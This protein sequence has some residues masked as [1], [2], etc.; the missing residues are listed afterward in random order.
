MSISP[1]NYSSDKDANFGFIEKIFVW[2][3][4]FEPMIFFVVLSNSSIG[5]SGNISRLLQI[6]V[7]LMLLLRA[8]SIG[9]YNIKIPNLFYSA[10][11]WYFLYIIFAVISLIFGALTGAYD[12]NLTSKT[13]A[14][15]YS[16][17][18]ILLSG[19]LLRP[20]IEL[21]ILIYNFIYLVILPQYLLRSKKG[22]NYFFN[23]FFFVFFSS[24]FIGIIDLL[25]LYVFDYE[26]I[27]RTIAD[28]SHVGDRYHGLAGEPRDAFVYTILGMTL[29]F[30]RDYWQETKINKIWY[31]I[32]FL[33]L[34]L[35]KSFSGYVSFAIILVLLF[36]YL[37]PATKIKYS[38]PIFITCLITFPIVIYAILNTPRTLRYIESAPELLDI[39]INNRN[40]SEY[41]LTQIVNLYPIWIRF[42]NLIELNF[43]PILIGTGL[44]S[45]SVLNSIFFESKGGNF[46]PHAWIIRLIF[47]GGLIGILIFIQ[48]FLGPIKK[49]I[50]SEK[51]KMILI[52]SILS[53]LGASMGHRS[54]SIYI[55]FGITYLVFNYKKQ[56]IDTF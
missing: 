26:W 11:K 35:T 54:S 47:E 31:L 37:L 52:I 30:V 14:D 41:W 33:C 21:I 2:S 40:I 45:S 13:L 4:V 25:L 20:F 8:L 36:V 38:L 28:W 46:N 9:Y 34:L 7:L 27:P 42:T 53:V 24:F 3:L 39:F 18:T 10:Y 49:L 5:I 44:G 43:L 19:S 48:S 16:G 12:P 15:T 17:F 55:F 51:V 22:I 6:F 56:K 50:T 1:K 32:F 23:I 29:L